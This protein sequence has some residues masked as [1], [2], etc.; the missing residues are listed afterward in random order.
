MNPIFLIGTLALISFLYWAAY[1][2]DRVLKTRA[3]EINGNLLLS[4]PEFLFKIILLGIC[5]G[6]ANSLSVDRLEKYIGWPSTQPLA[7]IVLGVTIGLVTAFAVNIISTIAIRIWGKRIYSP[8]VM[9]GMIPRNQIEWVLIL[10]PLLLAVALEEV[11]FRALLIGGF[12]MVVNPW[13]MAV[14]SSIVF[15]LMHSPQG[16]LGIVL[17][18]LVGMLFGA[19]FILTNSLLIVIIAHFVINLLQIIRAKDDLAWYE[20]L[21]DKPPRQA[22]IKTPPTKAE[23]VTEAAAETVN[24]PVVITNQPAATPET[25]D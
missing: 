15:G 1:Q 4:V 14:A 10:V 23:D 3:L 8:A 7:D 12:S 22:A 16:I 25:S 2:S 17:V 6:L 9:Q 20:R 24:E 11:L 13:I 5:F 21:E 18:G 19:I